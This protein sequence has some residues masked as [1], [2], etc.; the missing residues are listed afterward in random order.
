MMKHKHVLRYINQH[1]KV[2]LILSPSVIMNGGEVKV[3]L[4]MAFYFDPI[5]RESADLHLIGSRP[6]YPPGTAKAPHLVDCVF[7]SGIV[8]RP[9]GKADLYVGI[10]DCQAG[11]ITIDYPFAGH[12]RIV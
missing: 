7:A 2:K 10:G 6:C 9:D 1:F 8:M 11:R 12:G 3:Y 4:N 5:T